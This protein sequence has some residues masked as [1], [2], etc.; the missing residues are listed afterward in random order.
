MMT[1]D[2]AFTLGQATIK[3]LPPHSPV[4]VDSEMLRA[5]LAGYRANETAIQ[6]ALHWLSGPPFKETDVASAI[7][8]LK[9]RGPEPGGEVEK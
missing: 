5:L 8:S 4:V 1:P 9:Q 3:G 2:E 6:S 7:V